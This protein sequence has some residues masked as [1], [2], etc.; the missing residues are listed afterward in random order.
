MASIYVQKPEE[1]GP[2]DGAAA[3]EPGP[4]PASN[5]R[6]ADSQRSHLGNMLGAMRALRNHDKCASETLDSAGLL[7]ALRTG[8]CCNP[9]VMFQPEHLDSAS[10][11]WIC[12]LGMLQSP[13]S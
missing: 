1:A 6:H 11:R 13:I 3:A 10:C 9:N 4:P 7:M 8:C 5:Q 12:R 2:A